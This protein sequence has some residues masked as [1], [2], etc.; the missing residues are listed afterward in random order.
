MN[1]TNEREA[2]GS[3]RTLGP[4]TVDVE[5]DALVAGLAYHVTRAMWRGNR[6]TLDKLGRTALGLDVLPELLSALAWSGERGAL[7]L[8]GERCTKGFS[9]LEAISITALTYAARATHG[10]EDLAPDFTP[11]LE[12]RGKAMGVDVEWLI[13]RG[14]DS[15]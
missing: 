3:A 7:E 4:W 14:G 1:P 8:I 12:Q 6:A 2:E 9:S 11:Q 5:T 15:G 10:L 13:D